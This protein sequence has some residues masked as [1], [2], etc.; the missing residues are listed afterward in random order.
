M[1]SSQEKTSNQRVDL[2]KVTPIDIVII[3][4][5][6]LLAAG[7]ILRTKLG[8][9]WQSS[10]AIEAAVYHDGKLS[11]RPAL[12]KDQEVVLLNGKMLVE[13]K[14][15]KIR[16]KRSD[17]PRQVCVNTGW[18]QHT[19]EAIVCVPFKTLIEIKSPE[20]PAVDAVVY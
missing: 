17:C 4:C 11:E 14:E 3:F 1:N 6:L 19:G 10:G 18:I 2:Y 16:V 15:N 7:L 5:I 20:S 9:N 8:L 13:I 12:D